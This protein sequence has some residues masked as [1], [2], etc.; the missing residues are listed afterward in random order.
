MAHSCIHFKLMNIP[1]AR[2]MI[3]M[4]AGSW[5]IEEYAFCS[6]RGLFWHISMSR[7]LA[8]KPEQYRNV[9]TTS[10]SASEPLVCTQR[11]MVG[12][13]PFLVLFGVYMEMIID[14]H[15]NQTVPRV[16]MDPVILKWKTDVLWIDDHIT[17]HL[18]NWLK[19][20][21]DWNELLNYSNRRLANFHYPQFIHSCSYMHFYNVFIETGIMF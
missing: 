1:N 10:K 11:V 13:V 19:M 20:S 7:Q 12:T 9:E 3:S 5:I 18:V 14:T 6:M 2:A 16:T 4:N 17:R 8:L 15:R 21:A